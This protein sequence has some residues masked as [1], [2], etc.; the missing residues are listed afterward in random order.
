MWLKLSNIFYAKFKEDF[1]RKLK[2]Y[3]FIM[4]KKKKKKK[5]QS[6]KNIKILDADNKLNLKYKEW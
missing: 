2:S 4:L 5:K 1:S 6:G 3:Y